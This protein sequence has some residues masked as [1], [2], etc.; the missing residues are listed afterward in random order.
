MHVWVRPR[1]HTHTT[2]T[3]F[4]SSV[5]HFLQ[6]GLL[7]SPS[8]YRCL[9][10]VLCP[11]RRP[12]LTLDCVLLKDNNRAFVRLWVRWWTFG[13]H[14]NAGN[15]LTSCKPVSF[16]RRTLHHGVSN[17]APVVRSGLKINSWASVCVLW[18]PRHIAKCWLST[19][20]WADWCTH[21]LGYHWD[22]S[23]LSAPFPDILPSQY[24]INIHLCQLAVNIVG[25]NIFR[26]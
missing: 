17:Q 9:L 3:E 14:K 19:L 11:V 24:S 8:T 16:S 25:R 1:P 6:V 13:Y 2:W 5:P 20:C 21:R 7:L 12:V 18:G 10:R 22:H 4:S 23:E 15:F 26:P